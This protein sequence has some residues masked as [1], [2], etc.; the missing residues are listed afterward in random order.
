MND[1]L[2][3]CC[4]DAATKRSRQMRDLALTDSKFDPE[5]VLSL[6]LHVAQLEL[7]LRELYRK[8]RLV[9]NWIRIRLQLNH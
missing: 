8:V 3:P 1:L 9:F 2:T 4:V 6:L 5:V 7:K